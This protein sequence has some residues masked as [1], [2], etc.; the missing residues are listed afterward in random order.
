MMIMQKLS[1]DR[2]RLTWLQLALARALEES[3][4]RGLY[5]ELLERLRA[6]ETHFSAALT[7]KRLA[8]TARRQAVAVHTERA[9][10]CRRLVRQAWG[11]LYNRV[12][13]REMRLS[14]LEHYKL[15]T[16]GRRPTP[17]TYADWLAAGKL[18]LVG[19]A[20]ATEAGFAPLSEP[21]LAL[22]RDT[23]QQTEAAALELQRSKAAA[24]VAT[25]TLQRAR[26]EVNLLMREIA[27]YLRSRNMQQ[28]PVGMRELLRDYG[29]RFTAR[30]VAPEATSSDLQN[31]ENKTVVTEH[32]AS[33][34]AQERQELNVE[35]NPSPSPVKDQGPMTEAPEPLEAPS[36]LASPNGSLHSGELLV[37]V[38]AAP[39]PSRGH[40]LVSVAM[41]SPRRDASGHKLPTGGEMALHGALRE[42]ET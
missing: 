30:E 7:A 37:G 17:S 5:S 12:A 13:R 2:S 21:P 15:P 22:L 19:D 42:C 41:D 27:R 28:S 33:R 40:D 35:A 11:G 4:K 20:E 32:E 25:L 29:Y 18:L 39:L 31:I 38:E 34:P 14:D 3:G 24:R 36:P 8:Y 16:E 1:G 9:D 10:F 26:G 6:M 23:V